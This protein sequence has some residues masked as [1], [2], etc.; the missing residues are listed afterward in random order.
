MTSVLYSTVGLSFWG[1]IDP[2][3]G[4]I[5]DHTHPLY[6]ETVKDKVLCIP[7]GRGSCTGSQVMLELILNGCGP[8]SIILRD[9]DAILCTGAVIAQEFFV[10][11][12][13]FIPII[14]A[15]GKQEF[16]NLKQYA[17]GDLI[18]SS[19]KDEKVHIESLD[20][21][22]SCVTS[23]LLKLDDTIELNEEEERLIVKEDSEVN[24]M[25]LRTIKRVASISGAKELIPITSG[26]IDAVTYIGQGGLRFVQR[27]VEMGGK[28][29]VPTTLNSQSVDRRRWKSLGVENT[30]AKN[31]N[32]IGDSYLKLGCEESFTCAPYLLPKQ[33]QFND[34]IVWGESN[35]VVYSNS[36]IGARTEK[37]ADYFDIC[38]AI[39]GHVPLHGVHITK[40]RRPNIIIDASKFID[41]FIIPKLGIEDGEDLDSFFPLMGWICGKLSDGEIPLILGFDKI[42]VTNDNLKGFC[43]AFGTTGTAPLFHM[44][45]ITPESKDEVTVIAMKQ[46]CLQNHVEIQMEHIETAINALDSGKDRHRQCE[47]DLGKFSCSS[48]SFCKLIEITFTISQS[49]DLLMLSRIG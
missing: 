11:E 25:C 48:P 39:L 49:N 16:E 30:Y 4:K 35:A 20:K 46:S 13:S 44:A 5:I 43:A 24:K 38:C 31:A 41:N 42:P 33:P 26:H 32:A 1:G 34:Q 12:C 15:L 17:D 9:A 6:G 3:D 28:V 36:V 10:D 37:Y 8:R 19:L 45:K 14:C 21:S 29:A 23:D 2:T 22:F 7:T 27:L 40:N 18:V 47:I